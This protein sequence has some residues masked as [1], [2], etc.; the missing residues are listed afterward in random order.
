[1]TSNPVPSLSTAGWVRDVASKADLLVSHYF[2]SEYSQSALYRT[3]ITSLPR[4]VQ[5]FG[6]DE[7]NLRTAV[8]TEMENYL[9]R[10]FDVVQVEVT[11]DKPVPGDPNRIN[12]ILSVLITDQG[13]QYSLGR[14][15]STVNSKIVEIVNINNK[16]A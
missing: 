8:R 11:V 2:I 10:Y 7:N 4:Q 3:Q 16:G 6:N 5:E 9:A 13:Q 12:V 15:I 14:L 1:M